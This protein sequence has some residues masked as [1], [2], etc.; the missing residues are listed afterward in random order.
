MGRQVVH[1]QKRQTLMGIVAVVG[2]LLGMQL[3][4][5]T[6]RTGSVYWY[7]NSPKDLQ[8]AF[9]YVNQLRQEQ[10][11]SPLQW[12]ERVYAL[13]EARAIDMNTQGYQDHTNPKTGACPD[14]MKTQFGLQPSEFIPE[15][16]SGYPD[17]K[18]QIGD[19]VTWR[20]PKQA[21]EGWMGSRGHRYNL[22]YPEH[23]AGA[24]ACAQ[25]KCVFLGLNTV[26][27]GQGC[28]TAAQGRVFWDNAPLQP[29]EVLQSQ[30]SR[31]STWDI[32]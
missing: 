22:L 24:I 12:D 5:R 27:F 7:R 8:A 3:F 2:M 13:A 15:N 9:A 4:S 1:R 26:G 10:G 21:I 23:T 18:A 14:N 19:R 20:S 28:T 30:R 17:Y 31:Q 29:K 11:R 16:I 6:H 32:P 25:D